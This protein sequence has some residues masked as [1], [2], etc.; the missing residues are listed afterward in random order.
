M[1]TCICDIS[2]LRFWN[3]PPLVT[4]IMGSGPED[5]HAL[6]FSSVEQME[7]VRR[8]V[9]EQSALYA[10]CSKDRRR[11]NA[12]SSHS[13]N[14][15]EVAPLLAAGLEPPVHVLART[16]NERY[17]SE[18]LAPALWTS[19]I[20]PGAFIQVA[21]SIRVATP[22][23]ALLQLAKRLGLNKCLLIASGLC[24]TYAE[25]RAPGALERHLAHASQEGGWR[26]YL[27]GGKL[28]TLWQREPLATPDSIRRMA[29]LASHARGAGKLAR[30]SELVF[31]GAASP[32]ESKAGLILGL[33]TGLGGYG[34]EGMTHNKQVLLRAGSQRLSEK[35]CCYCDLYWEEGV[36]V[37]CQ[38]RMA[39]A[40]EVSFLSD[41]E[42]AAALLNE[43]IAVLPLTYAQLSDRSRL[44]EFAQVLAKLRGIAPKSSSNRQLQKADAL[45]NDLL[46]PF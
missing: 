31:P 32:F 37:E 1:D 14:L 10:L 40:N 21:E 23:F 8:S 25:Y 30:V 3:T 4:A 9:L 20:P 41:S 13:L 18:L 42:R 17:C 29:T 15:Q 19:E 6:G 46:R 12:A 22:E 16:R 2:A 24:G 7:T 11:W 28:Q 27:I 34:H 36:D 45:F 26:P 35:R 38:S 44:D 33:P 43:G 39:H 5:A